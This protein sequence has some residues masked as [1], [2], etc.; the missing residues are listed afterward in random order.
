MQNCYLSVLSLNPPDI[1]PLLWSPEY[2]PLCD[3]TKG[4]DIF[5][6]SRSNIIFIIFY[7]SR[8]LETEHKYTHLYGP[9]FLGG[10]LISEVVVLLL[11]WARRLIWGPVNPTEQ[12]SQFF[13]TL[14]VKPSESQRDSQAESVA[15]CIKNRHITFH[16]NGR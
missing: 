12:L 15:Q 5:A 13:E 10:Q 7:F 1:F 14:P 8:R 2:Q 16:C 3:V 9:N 11:Q 6:A 4:T